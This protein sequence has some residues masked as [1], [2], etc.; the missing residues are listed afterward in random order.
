MTLT[1]VANCPHWDLYHFILPLAMYEGPISL[2]LW[3]MFSTFWIFASLT[4]ES[5]PRVSV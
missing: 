2:H 5:G 3:S 4:G 1:D